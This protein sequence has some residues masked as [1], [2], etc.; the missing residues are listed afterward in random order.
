MKIAKKKKLKMNFQVLDFLNTRE[1]N[2]TLISKRK[3]ILVL[4]LILKH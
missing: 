1:P 4:T 2:S 3:T